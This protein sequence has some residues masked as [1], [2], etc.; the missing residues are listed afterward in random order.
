MIPRTEDQLS[1]K[2][3]VSP[4][5]R[6]QYV[7]TLV[8]GT[9]A[10]NS[11]WTRGRSVL[12]QLV[13]QEIHGTVIFKLFHW[14]YFNNSPSSRLR[15]T[16]KLRQRLKRTLSI[17]PNAIHAVIA[18]SHGG[19]IALEAMKDPLLSSR[20]S[21]V[22]S[23]SNPIHNGKAKEALRRCVVHLFS[24]LGTT[25]WHC[26]CIL[27]FRDIHPGWGRA[28]DRLFDF[29]PRVGRAWRRLVLPLDVQVLHG[30]SFG[31]IPHM[32]RTDDLELRERDGLGQPGDYQAHTSI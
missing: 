27:V 8:H 28:K 16:L 11:P 12:R 10:Q 6:R 32:G 29:S 30:P 3:N 26:N 5:T 21:A 1:D 13:R 17:H 19:N 2:V 31:R 25:P 4:T 15:A 14:G 9:F 7:L 23:V 20:I 18:H 24:D 22:I